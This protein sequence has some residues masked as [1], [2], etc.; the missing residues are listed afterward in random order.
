[1]QVK[2]LGCSGGIGGNLRT[3]SMLVDDDILIDAGTGVGDLSIAQLLKIDHIFLTHS[4][5]DHIALMPLLL[6]TVMGM[7]NEP[8]T[9]HAT[10]ETTR[11]LKQH[12]F[13]WKVWPDFNVIPDAENPLLVYNE[14]AI[15]TAELTGSELEAPRAA[16][17][18]GTGSG[19]RDC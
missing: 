3:T 9:V 16:T 5:L 7:R 10:A 6:D 2:I 8:V 15:G 13:N 12:I 1:M 17:A 4:H 19:A 11:I 14:V 18:G